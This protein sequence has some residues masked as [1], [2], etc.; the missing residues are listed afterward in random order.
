MEALSTGRQAYSS[1]G[2]E[3]KIEQVHETYRRVVKGEAWKDSVK[4]CIK[5]EWCP[6]TKGGPEANNPDSKKGHDRE[7]PSEDRG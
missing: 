5:I 1:E 4:S 3:G 7:C 6:H 2:S